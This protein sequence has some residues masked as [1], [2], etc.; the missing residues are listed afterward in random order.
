VAFVDAEAVARCMPHESSWE[1]IFEADDPNS[2][3]D[4]MDAD[5]PLPPG[6]AN[7]VMPLAE[8]GENVVLSHSGWGDGF[9]P[10]L[11]TKDENG[12][13]TGIHIDLAVV[14]KFDDEPNDSAEVPF[15]EGPRADPPRPF[16][17]KSA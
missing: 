16:T 17:G 6:M 2:W 10:V 12:R 15:G 13:L 1:D 5:G 8:N 3:F 9:Y 11:Q 4:L 7:I 14:G